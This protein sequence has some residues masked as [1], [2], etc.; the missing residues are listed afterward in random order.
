MNLTFTPK[1]SIVFPFVKRKEIPTPVYSKKNLQVGI[2]L[3]TLLLMFLAS[4]IGWISTIWIPDPIGY[5]FLLAILGVVITFCLQVFTGNLVVTGNLTCAVIALS[6]VPVIVPTGGIHSEMLIWLILLP[7]VAFI[8]AGIYSGLFWTAALIG[9]LLFLANLELNPAFLY[10][11]LVIEFD[12]ENHLIK[13]LLF[14]SVIPGLLWCLD[15]FHEKGKKELN[16]KIDLL[17]INNEALQREIAKLKSEAIEKEHRLIEALELNEK[18][19]TYDYSVAHDL[20]E[21]LRSFK[22]FSARLNGLLQ[23]KGLL[24]RDLKECIDWISAASDRLEDFINGF[25]TNVKQLGTNAPIDLNEVMEDVQTN[26]KALIEERSA[27]IHWSELPVVRGEKNA[28]ISVFQNLVSNAIKHSQPE[29]QPVVKIEP[30]YENGKT[31]ILVNDNGKGIL[32]TEQA[33]IF[34]AHRKRGSIDRKS[35]NT[36]IG[37]AISKKNALALGGKL[38][39][40]SSQPGIGSTFRLKFN[41]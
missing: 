17:Q 28:L 22:F 4:T 24:D 34:D 2:S 26:L 3:I 35:E 33:I 36:G 15:V 1:E 37:L 16:N 27:T 12:T 10:N 38:D 39:L 13:Y 41:T 21:P 6:L 11:V 14:F 40:Y 5:P 23:Q 18:L 25:I 32:K 7:I 19:E 30:H 29:K 31:A 9:Y 8:T 20:K